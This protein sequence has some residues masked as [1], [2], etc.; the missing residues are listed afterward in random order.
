[1]P[2]DAPWER[3]RGEA[4]WDKGSRI[5]LAR[6]NLPRHTVPWPCD[7]RPDDVTPHGEMAQDRLLAS[8]IGSILMNTETA[9]DVSSPDDVVRPLS[10]EACRSS[11]FA[12]SRHDLQL[13]PRMNMRENCGCTTGP[14]VAS[15]TSAPSL[16]TS[17]TRSPCR[18]HQLSPVST[19]VSL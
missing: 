6:H 8:R 5:Y 19:H 4:C 1:M 7:P 10:R 16:S 9:G 17:R 14:E 3:A 13:P 2:E 11:A 12:T 18:H 15:D